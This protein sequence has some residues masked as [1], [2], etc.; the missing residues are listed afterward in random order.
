MEKW[1]REGERGRKRK[2]ERQEWK[3]LFGEDRNET[4][5]VNTFFELEKMRKRKRE[6]DRER[7][8]ERKRDSKIERKKEIE[9]EDNGKKFPG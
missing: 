1:G 9:R 3:E 2:K 8:I 5:C 7:E 4:F 6:S